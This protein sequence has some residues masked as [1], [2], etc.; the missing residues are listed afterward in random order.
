MN[1][2]LTPEAQRTAHYW[3]ACFA[4][5]LTIGIGGWRIALALGPW[6]AIAVVVLLYALLWEAVQL[7]LVHRR[8]TALYWD[9]VLDTVGVANG[10]CFAATLWARDESA[11][12]L[13]LTAAAA[14][15]TVGALR[16]R[17][18]GKD[19]NEHG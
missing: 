2:L 1:W 14:I 13:F 8:G 19:D 11:S 3:A 5:H 17:N 4:G 6:V 10:A 9:S 15:A 18:H 16:R 7:A 12:L